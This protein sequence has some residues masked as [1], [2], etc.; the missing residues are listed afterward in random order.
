MHSP[1]DVKK[2]DDYVFGDNFVV[3]VGENPENLSS[4]T[5]FTSAVRTNTEDDPSVII[6]LGALRTFNHLQFNVGEK[7]VNEVIVWVSSMNEEYSNEMN[8]TVMKDY[9]GCRKLQTIYVPETTARFI[10]IEGPRQINNFKVANLSMLPDLEDFWIRPK[11]NTCTTAIATLNNHFGEV[12]D[13]AALCWDGIE[14]GKDT[15]FTEGFYIW[16]KFNQPYFLRQLK[17]RLWDFDGRK[18]SFEFIGY[19]ERD[20]WFSNDELKD[21]D[22]WQVINLEPNAY[23]SFILS[24]NPPLRVVTFAATG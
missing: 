8:W 21:V 11:E 7:R 13:Q 3:I 10:R 14:R 6:D 17:V 22:G 2:E 16:I 19:E 23:S 24:S 5:E 15:P 4:E 9:A 20:C 18:Q 1:E 12:L